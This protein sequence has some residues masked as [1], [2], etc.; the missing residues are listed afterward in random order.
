MNIELRSL[1]SQEVVIVERPSLSGI[2]TLKR[3]RKRKIPEDRCSDPYGLGCRQ[4]ATGS[5]RGQTWDDKADLIDTFGVKEIA[6]F[7]CNDCAYWDADWDW[8]RSPEG[9]F[10]P[11]KPRKFDN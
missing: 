2:K 9:P 8:D 5:M 7:L 4:P 6:I 1:R 11:R 10:L 3:S